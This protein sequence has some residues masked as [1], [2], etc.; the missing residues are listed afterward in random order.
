MCENSVQDLRN[1][2]VPELLGPVMSNS[3]K[4]FEKL[5]VDLLVVMGYGGSISET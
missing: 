3:P 1:K 4:F 2:L 5:V